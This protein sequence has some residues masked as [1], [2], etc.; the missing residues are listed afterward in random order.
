MAWSLR[1]SPFNWSYIVFGVQRLEIDEIIA[2]T[3]EIIS[4]H[5]CNVDHDEELYPI[6]SVATSDAYNSIIDSFYL[7][8]DTQLAKHSFFERNQSLSFGELY[9]Y[10]YGVLNA[11]Y[12]QQQAMLV[13]LRK[14]GIEFELSEIQGCTIF[15]IRN[16]FA[17]HGANRGGRQ[18]KEHSFI[19]DRHALRQGKLKGYSANHESG[20]LSHDADAST[21][22]SE[23]DKVFSKY[24]KRIL[25]MVKKNYEATI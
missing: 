3:R 15:D 17:A 8:E 22:I 23:W 2:L 20:F 19:L 7:L 13:L 12:M 14:M 18:V 16:S 25:E 24:L 5:S 4:D 10:F 1:A 21:L 11:V 6:V 9:L